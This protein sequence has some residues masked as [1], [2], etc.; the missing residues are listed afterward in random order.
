[1]NNNVDCTDTLIPVYQAVVY[2]RPIVHNGIDNND[3][4]VI[5]C[6]DD[7]ENDKYDSPR[8]YGRVILAEEHAIARLIFGKIFP[9]YITPKHENSREWLARFHARMDMFE[10]DSAPSK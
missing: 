8:W 9:K 5:A 7:C 3:G 1:M 6:S 10:Y 4:I 2:D